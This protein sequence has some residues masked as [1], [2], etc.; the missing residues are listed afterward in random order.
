ME[1]TDYE[2][3][4]VPPRWVFLKLVTDDGIEGWSEPNLAN[5]SDSAK[6]AVRELL[7][8]YLVGRD[9]ENIERH[10]QAMYR[11]RYFRGGPV[12][13]SA[14]AGI[15]Q[16][17]WDIKGKRYDTPVYQLLGGKARDRIPVYQWIDGDT[18]EQL[19]DAAQAAVEEG[20]R[21][22]K[23]SGVSSIRRIDS[24]SI[25]RKAR[26]RVAA[27][28]DAVGDDIDIIIDFR[29]RVTK[30]MAPW[31]GDELDEFGAMFFEEPVV[32]D[33]WD[34]YANIKQHSRTPLAAGERLYSRWDF[35]HVFNRGD[36]DVIQPNPSHAGGISEVQRIAA[37][38]ETNDVSVVLHCP[39]GPVALASCVQL[40]MCIPNVVLQ[41]QDL[42]IH[43]P[44]ENTLLRYLSDSDVFNFEDGYIEAPNKPGL[45]I[46]ID[47][48]TVRAHDEPQLN[49]ENPL[50][51]HDDG[52]IAE[53]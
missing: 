38:A 19:A 41:G 25:V 40:S 53:W 1:I 4:T 52:S 49:W 3:F 30:S 31:L 43:N 22:L 8:N 37:A 32:A 7:D 51:Y 36:V 2:L 23:L 15:N 21:V 46:E 11:T 28:R 42:E 48:S 34:V 29:G 9:P 26:E 47:E 35:E 24:P 10:W 6:A 13:M 50:W 27:V 18:P 39:L 12:L 16:A 33:Q 5:H 44:E 20:Y 45:G 14:I 17:L